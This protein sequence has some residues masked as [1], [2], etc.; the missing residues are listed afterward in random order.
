V[1]L[2]ILR[3]VHG[4]VIGP[5]VGG[6]VCPATATVCHSQKQAGR[7]RLMQSLRSRLHVNR[8]RNIQEFEAAIKDD[9]W[10]ANILY[11]DRL[12]NIA[13]WMTGQIPVRPAGFD[14]RL[15]LPGDG[16]AEW[17]D[18]LLP[19]PASINPSRGWLANWN[20]KPSV[21]YD[22]P[23]DALGAGR[24][25]R[26]LEIEARLSGGLVSPA[27]MRDIARDIARLIQGQPTP[28][29]NGGSG[30][31]AR[32][33]KPYLLAALAAVPSA[34][35]WAAQAC[36]ALEQWDGS[37]VGDA[38]TS[39]FL[40]PGEVIFASWIGR[41]RE[42][43]RDEL[44]AA[45]DEVTANVLTHVLDHA[46]LGQSGVPPSRDYFNGVNPNEAM[47]LA[48]DQA[49]ALLGPPAAWSARPR[50]TTRFRHILFPMVPEAGSMPQSNRGTYVQ[51]VVL[52]APVTAETILAPGQSGFIR[53]EGNKP[54][55]DPHFSDQLSAYKNFTYKAMPL[56][57]NWRLT[58]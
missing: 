15:P 47:S 41:M 27:D 21:N 34:H 30:R 3:S 57:R 22:N 11:A 56:F 35:E 45:A 6:V 44:G 40:E 33:V 19:M 14:P 28:Q 36:A 50:A 52:G 31:R 48:F 55:L 42:Y 29:A 51:I 43:F 54:V 18:A 20:N 13:Y 10:A 26:V 8:A 9:V 4:P 46:F 23:D 5:L 39:M 37:A 32:F 25:H 7:D 49:L 16:S 1:Q 17:T 2:T 12:G 38:V 58:P 24:Y 53:L